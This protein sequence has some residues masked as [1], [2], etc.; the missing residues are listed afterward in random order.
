VL[1]PSDT[2]SW[3]GDE[4]AAGDAAG[5]ELGRW[6]I[7]A[8]SPRR[9]ATA[10][11]GGNH[12]TNECATPSAGASAPA[13]WRRGPSRTV[14]LV[15]AHAEL[16]DATTGSWCSPT[17]MRSREMRIAW[18]RPG[19]TCSRSAWRK[20]D[21]SRDEPPRGLI[22]LT[23]RT[24]GTRRVRPGGLG[25]AAPREDACWGAGRLLAGARACAHEPGDPDRGPTASRRSAP[26]D[27]VAAHVR[28]GA[29]IDL[30]NATVLP[31]L[32]DCHTHITSDPGT[33]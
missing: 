22:L 20:S 19:R 3:R 17:A 32:I 25:G 7:R 10:E 21:R 16:F 6:S 13:G 12:A 11:A 14:E 9:V 23:S 30:R 29:V 2:A 28:G 4:Q 15:C 33:Y 31:G 26:P 24:R 27:A 8:R 1:S 5:L 18:R